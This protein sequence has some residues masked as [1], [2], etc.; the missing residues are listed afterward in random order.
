MQSAPTTHV[1]VVFELQQDDDGW[2]PA[3]SERLWAIPVGPGRA[4]LDNI[5]FFVRGVACGDVVRIETDAE[6]VVW[7]KEVVEFS[8]NC[9]IRVVPDDSGDLEGDLE[10]V[11]G[12][13]AP[14]GIEGEGLEQFGL[15]ALNIP[16]TANLAGAKQLLSEGQDSWWDYEEG[17]ITEDWRAL[18]PG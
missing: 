6:G 9:T 2:P 13:F 3:G 11:L 17:C 14:L 1:R 10:N 15:V 7:A 18:E 8:G 4:R 12:L 5:P 16:P